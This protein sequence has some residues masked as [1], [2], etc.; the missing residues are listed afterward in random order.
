MKSNLQLGGVY[1][2]IHRDKDGNVVS[3]EE[4]NIIP[5][6]GLNAIMVNGLSTVN[7]YVGLYANV[8]S[9]DANSVM[10]TYLTSAGEVINYAETARPLWNKT[11]SGNV[12][13]SVANR[14]VFTFN[15]SVTV[16]GAFV[17]SNAVKNSNAGVL[18]SS[19]ALPVSKSFVS[20]DTLE[21][22]YTING[23]SAV[24]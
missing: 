21:V 17:S 10:A 5:N 8:F 6:E 22:G 16:N 18:I 14:A 19:V 23:S 7:L 4:H 12:A 13:S 15:A 24:A 2:F 3:T 11:I 1:T 9:A 20:G